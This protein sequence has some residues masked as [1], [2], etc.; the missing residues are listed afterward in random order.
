MPAITLSLTETEHLALEHAA[1]S[2][3]DW[4]ENVVHNRCR[5]AIDEIVDIAVKKCLDAGIQLPVTK[6]EIV[7][8]AFQKGWVF[9]LANGPAVKG[10]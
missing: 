8:L 3:T 10:P 7:S 1:I 2:P 9:K 5:I 4:I 6:E